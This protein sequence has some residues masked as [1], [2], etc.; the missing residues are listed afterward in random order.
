[1][2]TDVIF[3]PRA[4]RSDAVPPLP[5]AG[6]GSGQGAE[7]DGRQDRRACGVGEGT[8]DLVPCVGLLLLFVIDVTDSVI[9]YSLVYL[10]SEFLV[11][12]VNRRPRTRSSWL[13]CRHPHLVVLCRRK[14]HI[15]LNFSSVPCVSLQHVLF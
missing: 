6:G 7:E 9:D 1:M 11:L 10:N 2:M 8:P 13:R 15:S 14:Q 5:A 3:S 12:S 4:L